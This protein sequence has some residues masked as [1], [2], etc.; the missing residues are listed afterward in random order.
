MSLFLGEWLLGS[1]GWGILHGVLL[2]AAIAMACVLLGRRHVGRPD[3]PGAALV[4]V[5]VGVLVGIVLGLGLP[6][7]GSTPPSATTSALA[8]EPGIRP[9]VVGLLVGG[10]IGLLAGILGRGPDERAGGRA[11]PR[12]PARPSLGVAFGAFTSITFGAQVGP[13]SG[14]PSASSRGSRSWPPTSRGPASTSRRSRPASTPTTIE[15]S[16]ETLEWLQKR[17]PPGIGS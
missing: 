11:S 12:S 13:A 14:S 2:F 9:L 16:K 5:V 10:L 7:P 8:V 15:T 4:G 6:E 1:M 17:M 3:R